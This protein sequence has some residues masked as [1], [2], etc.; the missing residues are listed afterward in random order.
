MNILPFIIPIV[1]I[2]GSN[3]LWKSGPEDGKCVKWRPR[4]WTY[5]VAWV[6][7]VICLSIAWKIMLLQT[8]DNKYI[9]NLLFIS[10]F[11]CT[12]LWQWRYHTKNGKID[13]IS[14]FIF[15]LFFSLMLFIYSFYI[16]KYASILISPL[17]I[18]CI[19]QLIINIAEVNCL[20]N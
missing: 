19:F 14:I 6:F 17:L 8:V 2:F 5:I 9:T 16:N 7:L 4:P 11:I 3:I 15:L 1:S 18:W 12:T 13:G 10:V 20:P